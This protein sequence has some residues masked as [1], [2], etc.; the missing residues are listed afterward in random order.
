[1]FLQSCPGAPSRQETYL[2][3]SRRAQSPAP[4]TAQT[5]TGLRWWPASRRAS[6]STTATTWTTS[7]PGTPK[8]ARWTSHRYKESYIVVRLGV[9]PM[10]AVAPSPSIQATLSATWRGPSAIGGITLRLDPPFPLTSCPLLL[11]CLLHLIYDKS[12]ILI[13]LWYHKQVVSGPKYCGQSVP[14]A[15]TTPQTL[16]LNSSCL[17]QVRPVSSFSSR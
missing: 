16:A 9:R 11:R 2:A 14:E 1:M 7:L 4:G 8:N 5:L 3:L 15:T 17:T 6:A 12:Y 13:T 10:S